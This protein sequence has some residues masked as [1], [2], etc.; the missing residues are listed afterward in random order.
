MD[1]VTILSGADDMFS[2]S[3]KLYLKRL[4]TTERP[5]VDY[6]QPTENPNKTIWRKISCYVFLWG[7]SGAGFGALSC[8]CSCSGSLSAI[9]WAAAGTTHSCKCSTADCDAVIPSQGLPGHEGAIGQTGLPG[10]N[11]TKVTRPLTQPS[12]PLGSCSTLPGCL[13]FF[14][15]TTASQGSLGFQDLL[16]SRW[17][18]LPDHHQLKVMLG[19]HT[20][21]G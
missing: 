4:R 14:R 1:H 8:C 19:Y 12:R 11:G 9:S 16:A 10:C 5:L 15:G 17:C 7:S 20:L 13:M 2:A 18:F 21:R 3:R 6:L